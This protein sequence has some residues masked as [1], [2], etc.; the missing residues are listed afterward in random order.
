ME[1][2]SEGVYDV[3]VLLA[4][5]VLAALETKR[6]VAR[7]ADYAASWHESVPRNPYLD[8]V[9]EDAD[10]EEEEDDDDESEEGLA[11]ED[12]LSPD[13]DAR[14]QLR[15][16]TCVVCAKGAVL[17]AAIDR[18]DQVKL[19]ELYATPEHLGNFKLIID[20]DTPAKEWLMRWFPSE[21]LALMEAAFEG[22]PTCSDDAESLH[23]SDPD[24]PNPLVDAA[25]EFG[26]K[27]DKAD[28]RLRGILQNIV[29]N[30]GDFVPYAQEG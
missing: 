27:Y 29:D 28:D 15:Q 3:R 18:F 21:Q 6:L 9:A 26:R 30:N 1:K 19:G 25:V 2:A 11:L 23:F 16:H 17:W 22:S 24:G 8:F 14:S 12:T 20:Q 13:K 7:K 5:D 4:Q 10:E